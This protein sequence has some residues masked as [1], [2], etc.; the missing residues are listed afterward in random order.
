M[1]SLCFSQMLQES[2]KTKAIHAGQVKAEALSAGGI[3]S[4]VEV[5]PLVGVPHD[6]GRAKALRVIAPPSKHD[7]DLKLASSLAINGDPTQTIALL[8][9]SP[10]LN[11]IPKGTNGCG[12]EIKTDQRGVKRLQGTRCDIGAYEKK[13]KRHH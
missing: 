4:R 5:D 13:V 8:K 6:V 12:T 9:G 3:Y 1:V 11:A 2:L 7:P 10:A